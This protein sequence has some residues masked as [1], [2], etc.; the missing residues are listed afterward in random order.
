MKSYSTY[1]VIWWKSQSRKIIAN[2]VPYF[3]LSIWPWVL[4]VSKKYLRFVFKID[5]FFAFCREIDFFS[6]QLFCHLFIEF[7]GEEIIKYGIIFFRFIALKLIW[8]KKK[9]ILHHIDSSCGLNSFILQQ[10]CVM[11]MKLWIVR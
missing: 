5:F 1:H 10:Y 8:F 11:R 3:N 9:I 7:F 6:T 2:M 4:F